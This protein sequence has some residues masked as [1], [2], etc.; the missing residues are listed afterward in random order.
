MS[1]FTLEK[2]PFA[3]TGVLSPTVLEYIRKG[4]Q[5]RALIEFEDTIEGFNQ[6]MNRRL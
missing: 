2:L 3:E 4:P 6:I 1:Y 5:L